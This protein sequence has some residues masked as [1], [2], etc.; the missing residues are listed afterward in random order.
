MA[1]K[2]LC[3]LPAWQSRK[4]TPQIRHE[5]EYYCVDRCGHNAVCVKDELLIWGGYNDKEG[6]TYC[7]CSSLWVY[8][9][10]LDVW[11]HYK[12]AG[13]VPEKRS[14]ACS[15]LVWP[16]WYIFC[17]H[18]MGGNVND[19]HRLDLINLTW[20][21]VRLKEP[22]ISPRDKAAAWVYR[23][24]IYCFGGFGIA[25]Y[26]YLWDKSA[27]VFSEEAW[28][29]RGWN[30]QLLYFDT[31]KCEWVRVSCKGPKPKE[32]AAHS[33]VCINDT[34]YL[35]GGRHQTGRLN[36]LHLLDLETHTWSGRISCKG[37]EPTGRSWHTMSQLSKTDLLLFGG[38]DNNRQPL[39]DAWKLDILS[40]QWTLLVS[41][42]GLPRLWHTA[43]VSIQG[44][45]LIFGGCTTNILEHESPMI[46]SDKVL[47]FRA[48]PFS[49]ERLCLHTLAKHRDRTINQWN[50]LSKPHQEWLFLKSSSADEFQPPFYK[51]CAVSVVGPHLT[52]L[53]VLSEKEAEVINRSR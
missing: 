19:M 32:R 39:D 9:L 36:D 26:S 27:D 8:N 7:D 3:S 13:R 45:V 49:L 33:A 20:E 12:V 46:T 28:A 24:R 6:S 41:H 11:M 10:D 21:R 4:L 37:G 42:T 43:C 34:V 14:G 44:D 17:G 25:P 31:E 5:S 51:N 22:N 15:A 40:L 35:F 53:A 1:L 2:S 48:Q 23:N 50:A 38:F 30:D 18:T 29:E 47:V 52:Q 16:Y